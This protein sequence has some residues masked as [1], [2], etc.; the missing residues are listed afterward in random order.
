MTLSFGKSL[1]NANSNNI[2][3]IKTLS[4]SSF[5]LETDDSNYSIEQV[6]TQCSTIKR[7]AI[8]QLTSD[9]AKN[10]NNSFKC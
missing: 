6:Y 10:F 7:I 8:E 1:L 4:N 2:Q 5:F 3:I 9:L